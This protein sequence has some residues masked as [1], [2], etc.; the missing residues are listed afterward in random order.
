MLQLVL[1]LCYSPQGLCLEMGEPGWGRGGGALGQAYPVTQR[2]WVLGRS[3]WEPCLG[4][5][6]GSLAGPECWTWVQG[7][8]KV[9]DL[10]TVCG[11]QSGRPD[12]VGGGVQVS[13]LPKLR[14]ILLVSVVG[15]AV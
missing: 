7:A 13:V 11:D 9:C 8:L 4:N 15:R 10:C 12:Y 2:P 6:P 1:L 14:Q 3:D 5:D